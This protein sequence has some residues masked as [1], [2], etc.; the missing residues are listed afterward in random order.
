MTTE[1]L[2]QVSL[3]SY[4]ALIALTVLWEAWLAP[5]RFATFWLIVKLAPLLL[6]LFGMFQNRLWA[7]VVACLIALL[8]FVEAIVLAYTLSTRPLSFTDPR[9]LAWLELVL[10]SVF[11]VGATFYVRRQRAALSASPARAETES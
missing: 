6:P 2:R 7:Y 4:L 11:F 8:Y 5:S 1:S 9:L 10:V 3:L